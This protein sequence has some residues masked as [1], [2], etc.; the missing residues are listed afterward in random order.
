[1]SLD[2][3][4][5]GTEDEQVRSDSDVRTFIDGTAREVESGINAAPA[6]I[7]ALKELVATQGK[8]IKILQKEIEELKANGGI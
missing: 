8:M 4:Y 5:V 3:S 6:S 1:M 7:L 2:I